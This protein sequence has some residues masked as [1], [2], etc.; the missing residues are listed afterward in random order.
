MYLTNEYR[1]IAIMLGV[2]GLSIDLA[3]AAFL[4][5]CKDISL[6]EEISPR[7]RSEK[8]VT[9]SRMLLQE[10]DIPEESRLR[11]GLSRGGEC[12][13]CVY[14]LYVKVP[15]NE[16]LFSSIPYMSAVNMTN[17]RILRSYESRH[18]SSDPTIIE[19]ISISWAI[20]GLFEPVR[21]GAEHKQEE[22]IGA[23]DG[24]SNPTIQA[25]KEVYEIFGK[26]KRV[27]FLLSLGS[28]RP[29]LRSLSVDGSTITQETARDTE[30]TADQLRR[31]YSCLK[32]YFR[33]PVDRN[34]ERATGSGSEI[35]EGLAIINSH[36]SAYL[37]THDASETLDR[38]I[39]CSHQARY[40]TTEH[41]CK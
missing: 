36:T 8:L 37:E 24:Y 1:V 4:R 38:C 23:V 20:P 17:C 35:Q 28:G 15:L 5:M 34:I 26:D 12:K 25:V 7:L 39:D 33:L 6:G 19:A 41:L 22:L 18:S 11:A 9:A 3:S 32:I 21:I 16:Q 29:L 30:S 13:V 31:R 2:L 40:V 10:L 27:C 14:F